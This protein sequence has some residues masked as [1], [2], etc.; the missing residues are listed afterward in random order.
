MY[1]RVSTYR[2]TAERSNDA[3]SAFQDSID[4][5]SEME[6]IRD[7]YLLVDRDSGKAMTMTLWESED[8]M[9]A[10]SDA[11]DRVRSDAAQAFGGSI[12]SVETYEVAMHET[13][14]R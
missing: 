9:H 1:A 2:A 7:A 5:I 13:F 10:S 8:T 6:G 4:R 3:A 14:G 12:E 11:A